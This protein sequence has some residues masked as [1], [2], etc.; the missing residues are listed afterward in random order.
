MSLFIQARLGSLAATPFVCGASIVD[1][2][3][4]LVSLVVGLAVKKGHPALRW[5]CLVL[6]VAALALPFVTKQRGN[7]N[8]FPSSR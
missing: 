3:L 8:S 7:A 6:S 2:P 4:G 5:T 1:M